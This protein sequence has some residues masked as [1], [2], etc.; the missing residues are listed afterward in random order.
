MMNKIK[1]I[2]FTSI[3]SFF[4]ITSVNSEIV[5]KIEISGNK[6]VSDETIKIYGEIKINQDYGPKEINE[7]LNNLYL[8]NFFE[9]VKISLNNGILKINLEEY[10]VINQLIILG[11]PKER[12][13]EELKKILFSKSNDSFIQSNLSKDVDK[14]KKIYSIQGYNFAKVETKIREVGKKK[15]DLIFEID[16]GKISK[17]S[18]IS[19]VGD[20]K[21]REKR[22]RDIIA[23]E[24]DKFWKFISRNTRFNAELVNLDLR[25]LE[26]YYKSLGYYDVQITSNSAEIETSGDIN[27]IYS[28]EAGS[29]YF[30]KKIM[31]NSDPVFDANLFFPLNKEFNK[32]AG[33]YYSPF[34]VKKLLEKIDEIIETNNLQFVEHNVEEVLEDETVIIKFNVFE[35]KK[36]LVERINILGNNVTNES[37][38]RAE[39]LL[40]EGDPFTNLNLDKSIAKIKS[41][42]IF[43]NVVP[44]VKSGSEPNLKII[45]ISVEEQPTGEISA[46]AGVG[47]NG[48][49]FVFDISENNWLGQGK[50]VGFNI[51][52]SN[53]SLKGAINYY[54]P[55]YDFLGNSLR[56][57]VFSRSN[58][59]PDQGYENTLMGASVET[60][61]EQYKDIFA[62]L[63]ISGS[64]DDLRTDDS[65]SASLKKLS[66]EFTELAGNYGFTYDKRNRAFMPTEGTIISFS[67]TLPIYADRSFISNTFSTSAY[68]SLS[69]DVIGAAKLYLTAVNGIGS[70]DVRLSK[71][72][73]LS[74]RRLR[75]FESGKIGPLDGSDHVG[76]NY[77]ASLNLEANLPKLLP[78]ST[79]TDVGLFLDFGNVWGVDYDSSID[80][81]NKIRS[82][83]GLT[84]SWISPLGPMTFVLSQNISKASTDKTE[85]FNFNLGTTF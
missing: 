32:L 59:K 65:A 57:S 14:I 47:T 37:V 56:Y 40:D 24:E 6:R 78:E 66:G 22:L 80:N 49:N 10:P 36:T 53:E 30:I 3:L 61:F 77:A 18:K 29:R 12:I 33:Q 68:T 60:S 28:I 45:D 50:R 11:E 4:W 2:I 69:E 84:A 52:V 41:R 27:L 85:S 67:Q 62:S 79:K 21:I 55:N 71:R 7:I 76:G 17:I 75:G 5:K 26:N 74:T 34:K 58:D 73:F 13:V 38:I 35:G 44:N 25:L 9:D 70:D 63:G 54:D 42:K 46:G 23:S 81:S 64:Y 31:I 83:A 43:K 1:K 15:L 20:K 39:L 48:G 72:K 82:S 19:F 8:T 16:R 51:D